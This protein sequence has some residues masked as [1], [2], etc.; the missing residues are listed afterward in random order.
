[1]W[2]PEAQ[3]GPKRPRE[4]QRGPERPREAQIGPERPREAQGGPERPREAQRGPERPRALSAALLF[5]SS[6]RTRQQ[7]PKQPTHTYNKH[8]DTFHR[9][10]AA[11]PQATDTHL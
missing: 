4:A 5:A 8:T 11:I 9:L 7:S 10:P 3:R 1:M 6:M 2:R